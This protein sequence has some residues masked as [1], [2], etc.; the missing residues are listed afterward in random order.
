VVPPY[1]SIVS[2]KDQTKTTGFAP[3]WIYSRN[4]AQNW[5]NFHILGGL[6]GYEREGDKK[7]IRLFYWI[8]L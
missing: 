7:F 3:L 4:Q 2:L 5:K 8:R 6:F 1:F